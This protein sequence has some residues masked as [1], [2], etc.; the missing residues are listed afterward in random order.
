MNALIVTPIA[1]AVIA[2]TAVVWTYN[3][4]RYGGARRGQ[5]ITVAV[6]LAL[7]LFFFTIGL[8]T[9]MD[10]VVWRRT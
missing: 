2:A 6:L 8:A 5:A 1:Y 9:W 4:R 3:P 7:C 10:I